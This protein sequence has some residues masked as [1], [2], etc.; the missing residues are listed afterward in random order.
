M[1]AAR[2]LC[3]KKMCRRRREVSFCLLVVVGLE[4]IRAEL[5]RNL[6]EKKEEKVLSV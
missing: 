3:A 6:V 4:L 1:A 5:A 2:D